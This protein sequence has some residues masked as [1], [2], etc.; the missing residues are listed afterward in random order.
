MRRVVIP[1]LLDRD[2]GS[3][4]EVESSL[5]DLG[6][7]NRWFGGIGTLRTM[8][9]RVATESGRRE[10]SLLDV[11][12]ASGDVAAQAREQLQARGIRMRPV[13]LDRAASHLRSANGTRRVVGDAQALPFADSS[14]D[15]VA[16]SLLA[17][18]L[19][20]GELAHFVNEAQRV[21]R[22]AVLINDLRRHPLH[23]ALVYAG[24]PLYRSRITRHD[25]PA[26]V[27]RAY[28]P[29][30]MWAIL[31]DTRTARTEIQRHYL[32]RMGVSAW[33]GPASSRHGS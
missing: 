5:R 11:G 6:R 31:R 32:Y 30:E 17:H 21:A 4:A 16:C 27:R 14:F 13:L 7:I 15:L 25:A 19:E 28:T 20:P 23:L 1:E 33:K 10:F 9:E 3:A 24:F 8:L 22:L 12:A 26:S 29:A 18:H 2:G